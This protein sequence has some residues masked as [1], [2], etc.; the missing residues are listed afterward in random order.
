MI[1]LLFSTHKTFICH[2]TICL[3]FP[4]INVFYISPYKLLHIISKHD[5]FFLCDVLF[6]THKI[7]NC[8]YTISLHFPEINVFYISPYKLLHIISKHDKNITNHVIYIT[9]N[10]NI[11]FPHDLPSSLF[12]FLYDIANLLQLASS[13][14]WYYC[15][16][17]PPVYVLEFHLFPACNL[18]CTA[19]QQLPY[20]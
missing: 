10:P 6:S 2:Y 12:C 14:T 11:S 5:D 15:L 19:V 7:F 20:I 13:C 16:H 17:L 18:V 4:E 9:Y 3:H 1:S 8:H